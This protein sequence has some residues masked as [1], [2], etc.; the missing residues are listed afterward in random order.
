MDLVKPGSVTYGYTPLS[1]PP[2]GLLYLGAILEQKGHNVEIIDMNFEDISKEHLRKLLVSFDAVGME[3]YNENFEFVAD[4]SK[5]IKEINPSIP[6]IVGGP[7]CTFFGKRTLSDISNADIVV[8]GDGEKTIIDIADYLKGRKKLSEIHGIYFRD[9]NKILSGKPFQVVENLDDFPIPARHLVDKYDYGKVPRGLPS[10]E[11]FTLM[12]T[13]RGC[14]FHC[15]FCG[16]YGNSI[17][18]YGYRQRSAENVVKEFQEIDRNY[19]SVLIV[20]D[21]FLS[22][23]DRAHKIFDML[24]EIGTEIELLIMGARVDSADRELFIKMKKANVTFIGFGIESGNQD[25]LDFYNKQIT[26]EEIRNAVKLSREMGFLTAGTIMF[27]SP[28][29]TKEHFE[30]TIN[31]AKSLPLDIAVFG[32]LHYHMGSHL[33][34]DAVKNNKI[35]K[36]EYLVPAGSERGLGNY[37]RQELYDYSEKAFIR[38]YF[39]P[40]YLL[41]QIYQALIHRD[42]RFLKNSLNFIDQIL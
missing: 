27:G 38:F 17:K 28:N 34:Y 4:Y 7:Y 40:T 41:D 26:L 23:N 6:L 29:E 16:R 21:H 37:S 2:L 3:V 31:F 14:P 12:I 33:W 5:T 19:N 9:N 10:K 42:F 32:V 30:N 18:N 39:R 35:K 20:D 36:D 22:D 13:S 15:R 8:I 24:I 1:Y 25:I 11:K